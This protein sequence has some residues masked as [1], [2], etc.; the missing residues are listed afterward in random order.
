MMSS[1]RSAHLEHNPSS[2]V[3]K[4]RRGFKLA[5]EH[6]QASVIYAVRSRITEFMRN[7]GRSGPGGAEGSFAIG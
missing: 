4:L 6:R 3:Q 1:E 2:E 5:L 7:N